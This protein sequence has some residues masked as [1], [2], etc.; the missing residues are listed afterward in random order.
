LSLRD[1]LRSSL[2]KDSKKSKRGIW[3]SKAYHHFFEGYSEVS[4]P[5]PNGKGTVIQRIYTGD[6]Y[7]QDLTKRQ[8]LMVHVLYVAIFL[9]VVYLFVSSAILPLASNSTW[10]VAL[11]QA[12]SIPFLFWIIIAFFSYL[13]AA[14]DMTIADYRSS[15]L[16]LKKATSGAAISLGVVALATL[17]SVFINQPNEPLDELLCAGKYLVGGLLAFLMN[18]IE[19]RVNYLITPSQNKPPNESDEIY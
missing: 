16:A 1:Q 14:Q 10:F 15:S 19:N 12:V 4:V 6:Y 8:R 2:Q 5:D 18:G 17:V 9:G 13:P 3:H 11:S 7:H